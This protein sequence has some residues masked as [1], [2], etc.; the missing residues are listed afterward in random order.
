MQSCYNILGLE[1]IAQAI[2]LV[3]KRAPASIG[4]KMVVVLI[5][6]FRAEQTGLVLS[7]NDVLKRLLRLHNN[8]SRVADITLID[9]LV[10]R[11]YLAKKKEGRSLVISTTVAGRN[12]VTML[13]K[14]LRDLRSRL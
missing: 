5:V 1:Y 6:V 14:T 11:N 12:Y 10:R 4:R 13:S 7:Q 9:Y 8:G 2:Y 3:N